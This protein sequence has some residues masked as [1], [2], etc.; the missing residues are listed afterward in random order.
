MERLAEGDAFA[1]LGL[2]RREAVWA[3]K[4]LRDRPL[5]LFSAADARAGFSPEIVERAVALKRLPLAGEVAEDYAH[6]AFSLR[7]HPL[8][9][10]RARLTRERWAPL[11]SLQHRKDGDFVRLAGLV[12]VRQRPGTA[13][14]VIFVT[15]ED[16][17]AI[18]NLVVW[19]A[20][21]ERYRAEVMTSDLLACTGRI[22]REGA[23]IH[24]V[25]K[26]LYDLSGYLKDLSRDE[27]ALPAPAGASP[28]MR[29][30]SRDFH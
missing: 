14:G 27:A 2:D 11:A 25:V 26:E 12:L 6:L 23:I 22:Q 4:A 20:T 24:V 8:T 3:V 10:L 15:I 21:F 7:A 30:A 19:S 1:S 29:F 18:A 5:P 28:D 16:E 9:F 13:S 17:N